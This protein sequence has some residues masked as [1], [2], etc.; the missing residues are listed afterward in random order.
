M[1][2]LKLV[3]KNSLRHKL[4]TFLTVLGIAI[5]VIAFNVMQT[6]VS[7]WYIGVEA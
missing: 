3:L 1:K 5:A 2:I 6:V 4:R 7:A